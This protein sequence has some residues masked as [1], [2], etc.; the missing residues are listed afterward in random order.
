MK[1]LVSLAFISISCQ[2][3]LRVHIKAF[4]CQSHL[5]SAASHRHALLGSW[6]GVAT[7]N[8]EGHTGGGGQGVSSKGLNVFVIPWQVPWNHLEVSDYLFPHCLPFPSRE[9]IAALPP[10]PT[11]GAKAWKAGASR[12]HALG[13]HSGASEH[14]DNGAAGT[15]CGNLSPAKDSKSYAPR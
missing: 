2:Q 7:G 1:A 14:K 3:K 5:S 4:S 12:R 9:E 8:E 11:P 6:R 13:K 15:E 10:P